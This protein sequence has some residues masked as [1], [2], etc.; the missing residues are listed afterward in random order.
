[1]YILEN[2]EPKKVFM[3]F[4]EISRIPRGSGNEKEA[5]DYLVKF[6]KDRNLEVIQDNVYNVI[7]KKPGTKGY[8]NSPPVILQGHIDIVCEKNQDTVHDFEKDPIKLIIDG[9]FIKA[10]GT[11]LGAD[12]GNAIAIAM[13]ILDSD[14]IP[15]PPIEA[16]FTTEEET[17]LGGAKVLDA[18]LLSAKRLINLDVG[19]EGQFYAGCAGGMRTKISISIEFEKPKEG[20]KAFDLKIR[21]LKGGHSGALIHMELGNSNKLLGRALDF[22]SSKLSLSL[23]YVSGGA[24]EN[25]IPREADAVISVKENEIE[26]LKNLVKEFDA[27]L[28]SEFRTSDPD[29]NLILNDTK[30][31]E[32][33]FSQ[34]TTEAV[35]KAYLLIPSGMIARSLDIEGL[36]ETST[37]MGVVITDDDEVVFSNATRSSVSTRKKLIARQMEALA[38]L[39][40]ASIEIGSEYPAW[41]FNA[42]SY[43]RDIAVKTYEDM[44]GKKAVITATHGG[45]EC[46]IFAEKMPGVDIIALG[47]TAYGAHTPQERLSISSFARTW[48]FVKKLLE[49]LKD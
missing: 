48:E 18:S 3:F 19:P 12:N 2:L 42:D 39:L 26:H 30:M 28:K 31:P 44:F 10:D 41:E 8:E 17:G 15:H 43:I 29:V 47:P 49:N 16:L 11:T 32:K 13:G 36:T 23:S 27:I 22:I 24:K 35:L 6:A 25:A 40:G 1:M 38:S 14:D 21:D 37:N 20:Y 46:G 4:E 45:L 34:K 7:I 33:V 5:S 9:D